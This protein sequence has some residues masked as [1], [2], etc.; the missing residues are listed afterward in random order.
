LR[1]ET[2]HLTIA[3]GDGGGSAE[4]LQQSDMLAFDE[5]GPV[6]GGDDG[7]HAIA[8]DDETSRR[9]DRDRLFADLLLISHRGV[10]LVR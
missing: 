2:S 10:A 8:R 1:G 3:G 6:P 4:R 9:T 7:H 5:G